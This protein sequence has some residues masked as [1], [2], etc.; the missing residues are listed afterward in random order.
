L[1]H[2]LLCFIFSLN[3]SAYFE[4][5]LIQNK[6]AEMNGIKF[7][8]FKNFP[9]QWKLISVRYRQD[10]NEMR[11]TYANDLA[12]SAMKSL[13]PN[14]P[15]GA[16]FGKIGFIAENDPSFPSSLAPTGTRRFQIMLKNKKQYKNSDGWGY[17]LF[18][19]NGQ[20][21]NEDLKAK[22]NACIAC[23]RLVPERDYVFS[24]PIQTDFKI[25]PES[26]KEKNQKNK[27]Y[28]FK[29]ITWN[30]LKITTKLSS[31][32]SSN[33][34]D[35][36]EGEIQKNAFSGTLD[37]IIPLLI[38]NSKTKSISSILFIN[39]NNFSLVIPTINS[40]KCNNKDRAFK[41][42]IIFNGKAVRDSEFCQ[43]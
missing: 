12:V 14:Y 9:Q 23:H 26:L 43:Q 25:N 42:I 18:D 16:A 5:S 37:E 6:N 28:N 30:N 33:F 11:F 2:I 21:Y 17:A 8:N 7:Q 34:I 22:T 35:S 1:I 10:S 32:P 41:I 39:Q 24:R 3:I 15:D 40:K 13:K 4:H 36:L 27:I 20:L 31:K 38:E 19:S 29:N